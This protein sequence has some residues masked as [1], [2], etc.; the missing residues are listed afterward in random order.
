MS[1]ILDGKDHPRPNPTPL[2]DTESW[3]RIDERSI[4]QSLKKNGKVASTTLRVVSP[5]GKQFT[6]TINAIAPD[7]KQTHSVFVYDKVTTGTARDP[8][9]GKWRYDPSKTTTN[10]VVTLEQTHQGLLF[11]TSTGQIYE[12]TS[13]GHSHP[14]L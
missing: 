4:E 14:I 11:K 2:A 8:F 7:G 3:R 5:D 9:V 6:Q 10:A 13:D 12:L 1:A